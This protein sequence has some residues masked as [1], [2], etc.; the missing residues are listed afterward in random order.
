MWLLTTRGFYSVVADRDDA[1]LVLVRSRVEDDLLALR[2]LA[3]GIDPWHDPDADYP[4]RAVVP[5]DE[6]AAVV[7]ALAAEIDYDNF[8]GAV[9]ARQ[10][11]ERAWVYA[12]VW[13][14]LRALET[15]PR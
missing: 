2:D 9:A 15:G 10:G 6:W 13:S 12:G 1:S 11:H 7:A 3:P 8:K 5:R 4:W 14:E